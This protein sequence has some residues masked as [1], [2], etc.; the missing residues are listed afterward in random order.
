M[1]L[2]CLVVGLLA[3]VLGVRAEASTC[4][5]PSNAASIALQGHPFAAVASADGCWVF[6]TLDMGR[7][8]GAVAVLHNQDGAFNLDRSFDLSGN[9]YG[10]SLT[11]DGK[12]LVVAD[13]DDT[14][15]LDVAALEQGD[16]SPLL[17][18]F[19]NGSNAGAIYTAI[20]LDDRLLF[21]SDEDA[22][23]ISIFDLA[24]ARADTFQNKTAIGHIPTAFAPVGLAL[25]PDGRWLYATSEIGPA[26]RGLPNTCQS[27]DG[28]GRMHPQGLLLR[29]DVDKVVSDPRAALVS[30]LPA[31]CNP[32]RVAVSPSGKQIWVTA[33]GGNALLRF[34]ADD[35]LAKSTQSTF[36]SYAI[37]A[38]PIGVVVRPDDKQVW[39]AL[40]NRF[41][42][43]S[44]GQ[45]AGLDYAAGASSMKLMT[46]AASGFPREVSFLPDGHTLV[47]T[48]FD[49][50]LV[51]FIPTPD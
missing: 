17:G 15:V 29:V 39:V 19:H 51:E 34:Q 47:A 26:S 3:L 20:S 50:K 2:G 10:A 1:K 5:A 28:K 36:D 32:V 43:R 45:I 48:L 12:V 4:V 42:K 35:W 24:Q 49:A 6:V 11:H 8:R 30:A 9:A 46:A 23:R 41:G 44:D 16:A 38:N 14:A 31:G 27:E 37:G 7:N 21:V 13:A 22:R 40:S 18:L 25:S 33:R